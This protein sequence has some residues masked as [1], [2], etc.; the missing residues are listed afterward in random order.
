MPVTKIDFKRELRDLYLPGRTPSLVDVP[1]MAFVMID[2]HGDPNTASSYRE[3]IEA[4]YAVAYTVKFAVKRSPSGIDFSVMSALGSP[5][6]HTV[7]AGPPRGND[8]CSSP[9]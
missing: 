5:R 3:A 9:Q 6:G 7:K 8:L 1:E 2:G 4:L